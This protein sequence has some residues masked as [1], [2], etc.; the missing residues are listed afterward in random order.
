MPDYDPKN[1]TSLVATVQNKLLERSLKDSEYDSRILKRRKKILESVQFELAKDNL[2]K[3]IQLYAELRDLDNGIEWINT[4]VTGKQNI[5]IRD[6]R[7]VNDNPT[8]KHYGLSMMALNNL[9]AVKKLIEIEGKFDV[10]LDA[11]IKLL[12]KILEEN[13]EPY[14]KMLDALANFNYQL[15]SELAKI[16]GV[17]IEESAKMLA[18][19]RD[20]VN[21]DDEAR[22]V[23]TV[24][25]I[26]GQENQYAI[27]AEVVLTELTKKQKDEYTKKE[28][29]EWY[30]SLPVWQR[31]LVDAYQ[32]K[33]LAGKNVIPTQ[34]R[35]CVVGVRNSG[36][37]VT[38]IINS[39][40]QPTSIHV[41]DCSYHSGTVVHL[42]KKCSSEEN[43]RITKL[44]AQQMNELSGKERSG[45][46][47]L[48]LNAEYNPTGNDRAIVT[49][50][51]KAM[52]ELNSSHTN[53]CFNAFRL[54][55]PDQ[56]DGVEK[57]LAL[58]GKK[59]NTPRY[60]VSFK[61]SLDKYLSTTPRTNIN[62]GKK[63]NK[64]IAEVREWAKKNDKN[65]EIQDIATYLEQ[66]ITC[67]YTI[68]EGK[69][70]SGFF[71]RMFGNKNN[72]NLLIGSSIHNIDNYIRDMPG[73]KE[74]FSACQSG[75]DRNGVL[76]METTNKAIVSHCGFRDDPN[77]KKNITLQTARS[78]HQAFM[79]GIQ[80]GTIGCFGIKS[81]SKPSI[82]KDYGKQVTK[83]I[84]QKE[85]SRNK[86]VLGAEKR[87]TKKKN[88]KFISSSK[89]KHK[90]S[91]LLKKLDPMQKIESK[92]ERRKKQVI[93]KKIENFRDTDNY[94]SLQN[95]KV[96][97]NKLYKD[98]VDKPEDMDEIIN[99]INK[100]ISKMKGCVQRLSYL[101]NNK[102]IK[103]DPYSEQELILPLWN[104]GEEIKYCN[105]F[106]AKSKDIVADILIISP[107]IKEIKESNQYKQLQEYKKDLADV[108]VDS[109][110]IRKS[111]ECYKAVEGQ[112]LAIFKKEGLSNSHYSLF[113]VEEEFH[114]E[115][116]QIA[117][118]INEASNRDDSQYDHSN[119]ANF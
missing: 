58:V 117:L 42:G 74:T 66:A 63:K 86:H 2:G 62:E 109:K 87:I 97:I 95:H 52:K 27:Q 92:Q 110:T 56:Y 67:K 83:L 39:S 40:Q 103:N 28:K 43:L 1:V 46:H 19:A 17:P 60:D 69:G 71:N 98:L 9:R 108:E 81:D 35:D 49:N 57:K 72:R 25:K 80:G 61:A 31:R 22:H 51:A 105:R 20:F 15:N 37:K 16:L 36:M 5:L 55:F 85:A 119:S 84:I 89:K 64:L 104:I 32:S 41:R 3:V 88:V 78:G 106:V 75:K 116:Q 29:K 100:N 114:N 8:N 53:L 107:Q 70:F 91:A 82:P 26:P 73:Y 47:M 11:N 76:M 93:L 113:K 54:F 30:T 38:A 44:N 112:F 96:E 13:P 102:Y 21:L 90:S 48:T 99:Q 79:S 77:I 45:I 18:K 50:S 10:Q 65:D 14:E 34:L 6:A 111:H 4:E 118:L 33:I 12:L 94:E 115:L 101:A 59:F 68:N 7:N 23:V 24:D